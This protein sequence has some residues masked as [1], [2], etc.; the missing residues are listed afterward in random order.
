MVNAMSA[1]NEALKPIAVVT[2]SSSTMFDA[3]A[4][5]AA[6][7]T[8]VTPNAPLSVTS[9]A[10]SKI[11]GVVIQGA[12]TMPQVTVMSTGSV[13]TLTLTVTDSAGHMNTGTVSFTAAGAATVNTPSSAGTS[14][15]ACPTPMTVTPVPP[16]VTE[17][18]SPTSVSANA[19]ATLTIT[20][21]NTNGFALTRAGFTETVPANL[22]V[23]TSPAPTTTCSGANGTLTS[24]ASA[25]TMAGANIPAN[26][27]C[28]MILSV[29]SATA[30]SYT[31]S[32]AANALTTAPAPS[33]TGTASASLTVTAA[34][35]PS[36]S[37][38]GDLDWL[39][40][41]FV[42]GVLLA[43]R[44]QVRRRPATRP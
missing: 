19:A 3:S 20:F 18:F 16:T 22:S 24:S 42:T 9:Y 41:M 34:A 2:A 10:W 5:V 23:Q 13:G 26:G 8:A 28:T 1:V 17:A 43:G 38:G 6:C 37:G 29:M 27:S 35:A 30:G 33:S 11:G 21:N 39:D 31:N 7:N 44:R 12:T 36:K 25:V 32:I 14:A 4:S 40:M 15:T